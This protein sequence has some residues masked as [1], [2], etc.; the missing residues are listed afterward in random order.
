[1]ISVLM[2]TSTWFKYWKGSP[3]LKEY[4]FDLDE[5]WFSHTSYFN[6]E[7]DKTFVTC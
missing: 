3:E 7:E 1:V 5:K 4:W 6:K 2:Y